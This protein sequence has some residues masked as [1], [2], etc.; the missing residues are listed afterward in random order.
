MH[1]FEVIKGGKDSQPESHLKLARRPHL[2]AIEG[3]RR[4]NDP[5]V[6]MVEDSET[7][8]EHIFSKEE[9]FEIISTIAEAEGFKKDQLRILREQYDAN[10]NLIGLL[11]A[12]VPGRA[13]G[14][15]WGSIEYN[16]TLKG[17]HGKTSTSIE[18]TIVRIRSRVSDPEDFVS[19][20]IV[21]RYKDGAWVLNPGHEAAPV[22]YVR[23]DPDKNPDLVS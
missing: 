19:G 3:S 2:K 4:K 6:V 20:G 21:A 18:T 7:K 5:E 9:I 10:K 14:E 17:K 12:V 16:Y 1:K 8:E 23:P 11:V 22:D 13:R 15:G